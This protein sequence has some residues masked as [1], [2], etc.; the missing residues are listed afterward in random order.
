M[1]I[2]A[3]VEFNDAAT[4]ELGVML[5]HVPVDID[6]V[7]ADAD[8]IREYVGNELA[9]KFGKSI[10]NDSFDIT[11]MQELIEEINFDEFQSMMA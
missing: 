5:E 9:E 2:D 6:Y 10:N 11:N 1:K 4:K 8:E 7:H 3:N